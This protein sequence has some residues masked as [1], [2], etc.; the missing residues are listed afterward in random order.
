M[1]FVS[2]KNYKSRGRGRDR[3]LTGEPK[4]RKFSCDETTILGY[5]VCLSSIAPSSSSSPQHA[6]SISRRS[7]DRE[8]EGSF[9]GGRGSRERER[10]ESNS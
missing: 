3:A 2:D 6:Q 5:L 1:A 7:T 8:R 10:E 9:K 4:N